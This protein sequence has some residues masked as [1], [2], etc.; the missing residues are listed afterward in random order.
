MAVI[1]NSIINLTLTQTILYCVTIVTG[2]IFWI[3][4]VSLPLKQFK[5]NN[6]DDRT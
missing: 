4:R 1:I 5:I 2:I 6:D 3:R